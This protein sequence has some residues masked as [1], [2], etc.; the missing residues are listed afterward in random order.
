[1]KKWIYLVTTFL[2]LSIYLLFRKDFYQTQQPPLHSNVE[3][4]LSSILIEESEEKRQISLT[5]AHLF[6][7]QLSQYSPFYDFDSVMENLSLIEKGEIKPLDKKECQQ[8]LFLFLHKI[9]DFHNSLKIKANETFMSKIAGRENLVEVVPQKVYF[10]L[11][12]SGDGIIATSDSPF[13]MHLI[14]SQLIEG[15]EVTIKDTRVL[16]KPITLIL[17]E[18]ILGFA[19]GASGMTC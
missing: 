8:Q 6:W 10:E 15:E 7:N 14:E 12:Q 18:T 19:K 11:L 13:K 16:D 4:Q 17:S 3:D 1:M 5:L 2:F 9:A